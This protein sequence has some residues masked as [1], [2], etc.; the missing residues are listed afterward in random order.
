MPSQ[1]RLS[2]WCYWLEIFPDLQQSHSSYRYYTKLPALH[3]RP[4]IFPSFRLSPVAL[5]RS[6]RP[7]SNSGGKD[8]SEHRSTHCPVPWDHPS[9]L[10]GPETRL[11]NSSP[12]RPAC[13]LYPVLPALDSTIHHDSIWTRPKRD[14]LTDVSPLSSVSEVL[15]S[16]ALTTHG[17]CI[18]LPMTSNHDLI[19]LRHALR[20]WETSVQMPS[21]LWPNLSF[22]PCRIF[23]WTFS[24]C[25]QPTFGLCRKLKL[26]SRAFLQH[27]KS[28]EIVTSR[29]SHLSACMAAQHT[30]AMACKCHSRV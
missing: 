20:P 4:C 27:N 1:L 14:T 2:R 25:H 6:V 15:F 21:W 17:P 7:I 22:F 8:C 26:I 23:L 11:T 24:R 12:R 29:T 5:G 9:V 28:M 13:P 10:S 30:T 3:R 16:Q 19:F 18:Q